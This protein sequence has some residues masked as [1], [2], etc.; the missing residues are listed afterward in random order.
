MVHAAAVLAAS[1]LSAA[2]SPSLAAPD[3]QIRVTVSGLDAPAASIVVHGGIASQGKMFGWVPLRSAAGGTWWTVLRAPGFYGVYPIHV[4]A[5]GVLHQTTATV[6]VLP[7]GYG[8]QPGFDKPEQ[9]AEW[10]TRQAPAGAEIR[11]VATWTAG[12]FAHRD[13]TLNRLLRVR[14]TLLGDWKAKHLA[15]GTYTRWFSV[16]RPR[17]GGPWRLLEI[18]AAP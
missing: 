12:F 8:A 15:A 2:V 16:A 17:V 1:A 9:V 14:F 6:A 18:V 11:S 5:R 10:W 13:Q 3:G 4:R 7:R